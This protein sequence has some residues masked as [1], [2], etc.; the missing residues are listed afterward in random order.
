MDVLCRKLVV[1]AS[2]CKHHTLEYTAERMTSLQK[3]PVTNLLEK[4]QNAQ[5]LIRNVFHFF[6]LPVHNLDD[7]CLHTKPTT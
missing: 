7:A 1:C 4:Q 3:L 5:N 2:A 6:F